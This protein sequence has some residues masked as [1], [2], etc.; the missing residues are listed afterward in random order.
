MLAVNVGK[1]VDAEN[2]TAANISADTVEEV[3]LPC[4]SI[5]T[6]GLI[7]R[8]IYSQERIR[9]DHLRRKGASNLHRDFCFDASVFILQLFCHEYFCH[10]IS[11]ENFHEILAYQNLNF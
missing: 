10:K 1:V 2:A 11:L 7:K 5:T 6:P 8:G 9:Q 4:L 3:N